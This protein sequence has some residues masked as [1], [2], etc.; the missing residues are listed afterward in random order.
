MNQDNFPNPEQNQTPVLQQP[1]PQPPVSMTP[2]VFVPG[3]NV[4]QGTSSVAKKRSKL[5]IWVVVLNLAYYLLPILAVGIV[6][7]L[8]VL[9]STQGADAVNNFGFGL[10]LVVGAVLF[11]GLISLI[12]VAM[13]VLDII[14]LAQGKPKGKAKI[15]TIISLGVYA[16][17]WLTP[18]IVNSMFSGLLQ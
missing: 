13:L 14:Y 10:M 15:L 8:V 4:E 9:N 2:P 12:G 18:V 1:T 11:F 7:G 3:S 6:L 16:L 17:T 5:A